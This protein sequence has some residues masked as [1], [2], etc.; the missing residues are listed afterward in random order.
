MKKSL[1]IIL[2]SLFSSIVFSQNTHLDYSK[3]LKVYNMTSYDEMLDIEV[4]DT[5]LLIFLHS[6]S[7]SLK[8]LNPTIAYHWSN[9]NANFHEIELNYFKLE[10]ES[11]TTEFVDF[12]TNKAIAVGRSELIHTSI[13]AQ[14]EYIRHLYKSSEKKWVPAVGFGFNPYYKRYHHSPDQTS[15][16]ATTQSFYGAKVYFTPRLNYFF[17]D[18]LFL[19]LNIPITLANFHLEREKID[20]PTVEKHGRT[21]ISYGYETFPKIFTA[22][23]GLGFKL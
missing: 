16:F 14:Y 1:L 3:A 15:E 23:V 2:V 13:S 22:R 21:S 7:T 10:K 11:T 5:A 17:S 18:K 12:N 8:I 6:T 19:D 9:G 4:Q 20:N